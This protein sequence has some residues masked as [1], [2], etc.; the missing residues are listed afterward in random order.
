MNELPAPL[1]AALPMAGRALEA[2]LDR[3]LALDP[4]TRAALPTLDG[5][6]IQLHLAAPPLSMELRVEGD[7][8]RVGPA[9][10]TGEPDLSLKTTLGAMIGQ[11]LPQ[12]GSAPG[13][14]RMRISGDAELA[15]RLQKLARGF[16]PDFDAAF[17]RVFGEVL[18]VQIARALREGLRQG[19]ELGGQAARGAVDY[20]VEERRDLVS[21]AEQ[22]AFFDDVDELR[23]AVERLEVRIG[24]L[25]ERGEPR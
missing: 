24:R 6:R 16:D 17:S 10:T 12:A 19:R 21:R 3:V 25:P 8:L 20:L 23:D 14:G 18:G 5:R 13:A 15:Q 11:L 22:E 2:A 7:R 1:R 4:E 9:T